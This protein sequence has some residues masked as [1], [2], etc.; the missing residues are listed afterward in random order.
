[1]LWGCGLLSLFTKVDSQ[2]TVK[3]VGGVW[4]S[5]R[6]MTGR[7]QQPRVGWSELKVSCSS[8][9]CFGFSDNVN[10]GWSRNSS[11]FCRSWRP[12]CCGVWGSWSVQEGAKFCR[13]GASLDDLT[14]NN[15]YTSPMLYY[16]LHTQQNHVS[17]AHSVV[18]CYFLCETWWISLRCSTWILR[19][20]FRKP[21]T[22]AKDSLGVS[23]GNVD[24]CAS[25]NPHK[26]WLALAPSFPPHHSF[27]LS[28]AVLFLDCFILCPLLLSSLS[29]PYSPVLFT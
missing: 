7:F 16:S 1:M 5:S 24:L 19:L 20:W 28:L 25:G 9:V 15:W 8:S 6:H 26:W 12:C 2:L 29:A 4:W 3:R 23:G 27:L 13:C 17:K 22:Q 18:T 21:L 11:V 14:L 10:V